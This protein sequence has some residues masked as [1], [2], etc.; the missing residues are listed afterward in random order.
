MSMKIYAFDAINTRDIE[1][2]SAIIIIVCLVAY[3][4]FF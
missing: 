2:I 1:A 3:N 4:L